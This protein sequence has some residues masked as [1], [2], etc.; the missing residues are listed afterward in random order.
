VT[1]LGAGMHDEE[2]IFIAV[3]WKNEATSQNDVVG[4]SLILSDY[5]KV[6]L[7]PL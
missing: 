5:S 1:S 4:N 3:T 6:E 2:S 7:F